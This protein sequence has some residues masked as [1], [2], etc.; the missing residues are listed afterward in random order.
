V[1]DPKEVPGRRR[2]HE[3]V[4]EHRRK[5]TVARLLNQEGLRTRNGSKFT[6]TTIERLIRDTTAKGTRRAN[7]TKST[8]DKKHWVL[9]PEDEW[10][11]SPVESIVSEELWTQCNAILDERRVNGTLPAKRAS[12]LFAG[13]AFCE[14]GTK[15][16]VIAGYPKYTCRACRNKI[17]ADKL[18]E[19]F[20]EQLKDFFLSSDELADCFEQADAQVVEK[21]EMLTTLKAERDSVHVEMDKVYKLYVSDQISAEGFGRTYKPLEERGKALN[22]RLPKLQAELD[23]LRIQNLSRDEI[24]SEAQDLY[25]RWTDLLPDEKRQIVENVVERVTIGNGEVSID[26][27]YIPSSSELTSKR[28]RG[29]TGSSRRPA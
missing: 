29:H 14:C 9:K 15:M 22:D 25:G 20:R 13:V 3:V 23:F 28:Q 16:Y 2:L 4:L 10:V 19:I 21:R 27:A 6:D 12:H 7:Y 5:K 24:V 11:L 17:P 18:E 26:L 1:P 8:G